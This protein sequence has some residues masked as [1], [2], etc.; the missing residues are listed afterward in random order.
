MVVKACQSAAK[1]YY[2]VNF[3]GGWDDNTPGMTKV[4]EMASK[5]GRDTKKM[6]TSLYTSGA[7]VGMLFEEGIRRAGQD[8]TPESLRSSLETLRDFDMGGVV[9]P[10]T[11][12]PTSHEPTKRSRIYKADPDAGVM[13]AVSDWRVPKEIK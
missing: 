11:F 5:H 1:N 12:T 6:L 9:P 3:V 4:R 7:A 8:L 13:K 10:V 2:G